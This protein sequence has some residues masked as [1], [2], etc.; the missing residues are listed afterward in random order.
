LEIGDYLRL[1]RTELRTAGETKGSILANSMEAIL[2]AMYLDGGIEPVKRLAA[3]SF[4]SAF[5]PGAPRVGRDPKTEFQEWI[6]AKVGE[7]P[8]Y[9]MISDSELEGDEGRF[10]CRVI[11]EQEVWGEGV[12]RTKRAAER[13]AAAAALARGCVEDG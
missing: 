7:F 9:E 1:G 13:A 6:V 11:V 10:A 12:G 3:R 2:G 4:H 5:E 8:R